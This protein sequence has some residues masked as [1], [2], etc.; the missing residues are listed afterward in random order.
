MCLWLH[1]LHGEVATALSDLEVPFEEEVTSADALFKFDIV[2]RR[3][4][5]PDVVIEVDGPSH[6]TARQPYRPL[7]ATQIRNRLFNAAGHAGIALAFF[8]W[9]RQDSKEAKADYLKQRLDHF[10]KQRQAAGM[11]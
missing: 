9:V 7:G 11:P 4:A 1:R 8:Q 6:F 5:R 3:T 2:V 10:E